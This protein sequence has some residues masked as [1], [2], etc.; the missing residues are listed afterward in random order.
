MRVGIV[1]AFKLKSYTQA[2]ARIWLIPCPRSREIQTESLRC[3]TPSIFGSFTC[4][5]RF[6]TD[7]EHENSLPPGAQVPDVSDGLCR[8]ALLGSPHVAS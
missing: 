4:V 2:Q 5:L 7:F 1:R 6:E 3:T 8:H